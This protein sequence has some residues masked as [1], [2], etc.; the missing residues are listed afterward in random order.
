M[1]DPNACLRGQSRNEGEMREQLFGI[2]SR[3]KV[4]MAE[5]QAVTIQYNTMIHCGIT[6]VRP[7]KGV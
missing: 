3:L 7:I 4:A 6:T 2:Q 1:R 5:E